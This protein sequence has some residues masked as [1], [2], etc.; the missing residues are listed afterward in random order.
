[1]I[2]SEPESRVPG[3]P[4]LRS[5]PCRTSSPSVSLVNPS[6]NNSPDRLEKQNPH[7]QADTE[8][9]EGKQVLCTHK[10]TRSWDRGDFTAEPI[11]VVLA[12]FG[13][14]CI[15]LFQ[16]FPRHSSRAQRPLL[17]GHLGANPSFLEPEDFGAVFTV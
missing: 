15:S 2:L 4:L 9:E 14:G 6:K 17:K 5:S 12:Q 10:L 13:P 1:M 8:M 11:A 7:K 3:L 16:T